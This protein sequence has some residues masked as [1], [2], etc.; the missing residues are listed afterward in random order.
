MEQKKWQFIEFDSNNLFLMLNNAIQFESLTPEE[1]FYLEFLFYYLT[2]NL[3]GMIKLNS[4]KIS[5]VKSSILKEIIK[6]R[7]NLKQ[8][9]NEKIDP[10]NIDYLSEKDSVLEAEYHFVCG[11][12][13][14]ITHDFRAMFLSFD[15]AEKIFNINSFQ[16][17]ELKSAH[18]SVT[19]MSHQNPSPEFIHY[20]RRLLSK[21][22]KV[23][24]I[25]IQRMCLHNISVHFLKLGAEK[26]ALKYAYLSLKLFDSLEYNHDHYLAL[27]NV[28]KIHISQ[29]NTSWDRVELEQCLLSEFSDIKK[30]AQILNDDFL[31]IEKF[32]PPLSYISNRIESFNLTQKENQVFTLL[33]EKNILQS[34]LI[35]E[36]FGDKI[37]IYSGINRANNLISRVRKKT[38]YKIIIENGYYKMINNIEIAN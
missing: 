15:K 26:I 23:K 29:K 20:Y 12:Y 2:N 11:L 7:I 6:I 24:N 22:E 21:S 34:D 4:N 33:L 17:K 25:S 37:D 13:H 1:K 3:N 36:L 27:L 18:N 31:K 38:N 32:N 28:S 16:E 14:Q 8:G 35:K 10:F 9:H 30:I 19:A 5:I